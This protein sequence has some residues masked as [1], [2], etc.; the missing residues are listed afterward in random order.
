MDSGSEGRGALPRGRWVHQRQRATTSWTPLQRN[1][2]WLKNRRRLRS[3]S[4]ALRLLI[5][6]SRRPVCG[7]ARSSV[8]S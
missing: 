8:I 4:T 6:P 7:S 5:V 2:S 1:A 3:T